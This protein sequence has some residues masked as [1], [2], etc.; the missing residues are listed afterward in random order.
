MA[1]NNFSH[2][3][4]NLLNTGTGHYLSINDARIYEKILRYNFR[5]G[6]FLYDAAL[7]LEKQAEHHLLEFRA[8]RKKAFY[9]KYKK[10]LEEALSTMRKS[11]KSGFS[12][13]GKEILRIDK[14]LDGKTAGKPLPIKLR[15]FIILLLVCFTAGLFIPVIAYL[16][17]LR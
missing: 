2:I 7:T 15:D 17:L 16:Y 3:S 10:G 14:R 13:A 12:Y 6:R 8:T 9:K 1:A 11:W 4:K 5:D